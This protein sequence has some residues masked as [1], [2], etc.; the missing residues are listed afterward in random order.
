[1]SAF[2]RFHA[3]ILFQNNWYLERWRLQGCVTWAKF[4]ET[5]IRNEALSNVSPN[6][7]FLF[8]KTGPKLGSRAHWLL[9]LIFCLDDHFFFSHPDSSP[10]PRPDDWRSK[11]G[12]AQPPDGAV[13][14]ADGRHP[15]AEPLL[16]DALIGFTGLLNKTSI[17][18]VSKLTQVT[19]TLTLLL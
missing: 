6:D 4:V 17:K 2:W 11:P 13:A 16:V 8:R 7:H 12:G 9:R 15:T 18:D 1:M 5:K 14:A 19:V 10:E 3:E